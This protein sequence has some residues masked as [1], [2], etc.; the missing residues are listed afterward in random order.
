[1]ASCFCFCCFSLCMQDSFPLTVQSCIMPK[2]CETTEWSSWSPCSKTCHSGSL[3]PGFRSRS[4]NVK[5]IAIGGGKECPE[6][7][8]KEACIVEGEL[9]QPCP[10]YSWRTSEWKECQVSLLL[11]QQD[12]HWHVTGPVCGGGI[13]TREVY[14]AHSI[15]AAAAQRAKEVSR[16][17]KKALC[18]GPAPPASQL[19]SV[20]CS[21]DCIV[22]SWSAWGLCIH[23]NCHHP[24]G[25][26]GFRMRQRH[27]L[28]E[29]TGPAAHCPHLVESVP[30]EDPVCY[31]WLA[32][33]GICIPDHGKCGL[34]HRILKAICQDDR[35][36]QA[37]SQ[38]LLPLPVQ[39]VNQ[40]VNQSRINNPD[41]Q[42]STDDLELVHKYRTPCF[43]VGIT[44]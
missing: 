23:E 44:L 12:P 24:Q 37:G 4:R 33:E 13:Q 9:L 26:K 17:V 39:V 18:L 8:E 38:I 27:V 43:S 10:R 11:E 6:L 3:S 20:P 16:P 28:M 40:V 25:R 30:C 15:P 1:M 29:S 31:R 35:V 2:D 14:C 34:G 5:H 19:C 7:L 41:E 21:T 32:S 42:P 36:C 22:S